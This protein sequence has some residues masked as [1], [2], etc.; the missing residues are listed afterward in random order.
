ML[1]K[2]QTTGFTSIEKYLKTGDLVLM[3]GIHYSSRCIEA[4]EGSNWS[5][6]G[7][8]VLPEDIGL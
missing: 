6:V 5:H 8:I 2:K 4:L 7:I 3:H 1:L